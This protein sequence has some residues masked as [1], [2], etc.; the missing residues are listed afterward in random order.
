MGERLW[1]EG[2]EGSHAFY[3]GEGVRNEWLSELPGNQT[4]RGGGGGGE[5]KD[6]K[7]LKIIIII[8][9]GVVVVGTYSLLAA[10]EI[11][12]PTDT[13]LIGSCSYKQISF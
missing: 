7:K 5:E 4:R 10:T 12:S 1:V 11:I 8:C 2:Y 13:A 6:K 9:V 3:T